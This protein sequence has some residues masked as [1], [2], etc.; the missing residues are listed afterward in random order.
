VTSTALTP[1]QS[2]ARNMAAVDAHFHNEN[3]QD[4]DKAIAL[5]ADC[6]VWEAPARGVLLRD[7]DVVKA[8]YLKM[9]ESYKIHSLTPVRRFAANNWVVD[10]TVADMTLVGDVE[11]N[12]PGCPLPSGTRVSLRVVHI[13]ELNEDGRIIRENAYELFRRADRPID[14]DIPDNAPT[15]T[16][17]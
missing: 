3:P 7:R 5:Y 1:E 9:F 12:V 2:V 15:V 14:D 13:F 8:A 16:F 4:I 10:D 6:I 11:H 17:E